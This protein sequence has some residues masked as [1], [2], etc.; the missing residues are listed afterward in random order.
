M[1][2]IP[3]AVEMIPMEEAPT[4]RKPKPASRDA[5]V[6]HD[7]RTQRTVAFIP[8]AT[9]NMAD[10]QVHALMRDAI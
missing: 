4:L 5:Y 6:S 3:L 10:D 7:F 8:N 2:S 9:S 1:Y